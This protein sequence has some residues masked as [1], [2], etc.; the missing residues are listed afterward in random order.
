[1]AIKPAGR[2]EASGLDAARRIVSRAERR[3]LERAEAL[4]AEAEELL[5]MVSG[6]A[7]DAELKVRAEFE[8]QMRALREEMAEASRRATVAENELELLRSQ[9][10]VDVARTEMVTT[11]MADPAGAEAKRLTAAAATPAGQSRAQEESEVARSREEA[12][13]LL[14]AASREAGELLSSAMAAIE[15]DHVATGSVRQKADEELRAATSIRQEL[16]VALG[17]A[18]EDAARIREEGIVTR[19]RLVHEAT[20]HAARLLDE[21]RAEAAQ[22]IEVARAEAERIRQSD[23]SDQESRQAEAD[24]L[25]AAARQEAIDGVNAVRRQLLAEILGLRDAMERAR[26]S[27]G[28]FVGSAETESVPSDRVVGG[29]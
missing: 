29:W 6:Q 1:M 24:R 25:V 26:E 20:A 10:G 16:E 5:K 15:T 27:F 22:I 17:Q 18:T 2:S 28:Q 9:A 12:V 23:A 13:G 21:A 19:D 8:A 4:S 14:A 7:V 11:S 3:A